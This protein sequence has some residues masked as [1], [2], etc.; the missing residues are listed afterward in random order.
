MVSINLLENLWSMISFFDSYFELNRNDDDL[1][2]ILGILHTYEDEEKMLDQGVGDDFKKFY[3]DVSKSD[4][5]MLEGL[6]VVDQFNQ[7]YL[8]DDSFGSNFAR[9][10]NRA[11]RKVIEMT[12]EDRKNN[13]VWKNWVDTVRM[14]TALSFRLRLSPFTENTEKTEDIRESQSILYFGDNTLPNLEQPIIGDYT[15][16]LTSIQVLDAVKQFLGHYLN[17]KDQNIQRLYNLLND[18]DN[19]DAYHH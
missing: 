1:G 17:S 16:R 9:R 13:Q 18:S 14:V 19:L 3:L 11:V 10:L 6:K 2:S 7:E 8:I 4:H 5:T 12:N 15:E